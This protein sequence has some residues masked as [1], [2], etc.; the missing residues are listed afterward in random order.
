MTW[1]KTAKK[2][3]SRDVYEKTKKYSSFYMELSSLN[4][5][6]K[7]YKHIFDSQNEQQ[8]QLLEN[9][10]KQLNFLKSLEKKYGQNVRIQMSD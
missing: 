2:I 1:R 6:I 10:E 7:L 4:E 9:T 5:K 8:H 3:L